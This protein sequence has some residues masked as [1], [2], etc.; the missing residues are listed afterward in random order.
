MHID[1]MINSFIVSYGIISI[2]LLIFLEYA[3]V[4]L[5]SEATLPLMAIFIT[6]G[7]ISFLAAIVASTLVGL[8]GSIVSYLSGKFF[9][10][11]LYKYINMKNGKLKKSLSL[12]L[13]YMKKYGKF[14]MS[15][16]RVMP[17]VRTFISIP[18]GISGMNIYEFIIYSTFGIFAWNSILIYLGYILGSNIEQISYIMSKYSVIICITA[19]LGIVI[20]YFMKKKNITKH[21]RRM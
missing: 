11:R 18:A 7:K 13:K 3:G 20:F 6:S 12:S 2:F 21:R 4:P 15:I 17:V 16:A 10:D 14:S 5:P 19:I 9:K 1:A 8:L